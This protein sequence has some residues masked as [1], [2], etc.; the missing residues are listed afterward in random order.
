[1]GA[2]EGGGG[3]GGGGI[4]TQKA[5]ACLPSAY[6]SGSGTCSSSKGSSTHL[7]IGPGCRR[8]LRRRRR[9]ACE[10]A[11]CSRRHPASP[12]CCPPLSPLPPP[13]PGH[14]A[15]CRQRQARAAAGSG[16]AHPGGVGM[17]ASGAT[18]RVSSRR[19]PVQS[20]MA[21]ALHLSL[22]GMLAHRQADGIRTWQCG[23][24]AEAS[25]SACAWRWQCGSERRRLALLPP[26]AAWRR[27]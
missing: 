19:W 9:L 2:Y 21:L 1:M 3:G 14:T 5:P 8:L 26:A 16:S 18:R 12:H 17:D 10:A 6:G 13:P 23:G 15:G 20:F 25:A 22:H 11:A 4:S 27:P 24:G 7:Q